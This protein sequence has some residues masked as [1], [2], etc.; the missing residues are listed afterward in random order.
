MHGFL[1]VFQI[2]E[3]PLGRILAAG[4]DLRRARAG[5]ETVFLDVGGDRH[6]PDEVFA[7][8]GN[9]IPVDV[10]LF[11]AP[12]VRDN[13]AGIAGGLPGGLGHIIL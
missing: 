2:G 4:V 7:R 9:A 5:H 11:V 10:G 1:A 12:R 6:Q 8:A 3:T 13:V